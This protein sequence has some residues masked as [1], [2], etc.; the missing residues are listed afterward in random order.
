MKS[1]KPRN[2]L[3]SI[4]A[5]FLALAVLLGTPHWTSAAE[6]HEQNEKLSLLSLSYVVSFP[7]AST[8]NFLDNSVS[9][10]GLGLE[11][12]SPL[13]L[14]NL[15]WGLSLRWLYLRHNEDQGSLTV[16][17]TT[18]TGK[19]YRSIDS[20]PL[21]V[22]LKYPIMAA[23]SSKILPFIGLGIGTIYGRREL[24]IGALTQ[25]EFGWQFLMAPE[26]GTLYKFSPNSPLHAFFNV[27]YDAGFGSD[28]IN[29]ISNLSLALGIGSN[30]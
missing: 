3:A 8:A 14:D 30:L 29:A 20:F 28:A 12:D 26:V 5:F 7:T 23:S 25:D 22:H 24:D 15:Y 21:A 10:R 27:R 9:Y 16:G 6:S 2:T 19:I 13:G 17:N 1:I 18:A 11:W 4:L